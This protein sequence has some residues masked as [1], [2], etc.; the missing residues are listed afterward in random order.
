MHMQIRGGKDA[1]LGMPGEPSQCP[2]QIPDEEERQGDPYSTP[3]SPGKTR[4]G[5]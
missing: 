1:P 4:Q 5:R 2:E 3:G